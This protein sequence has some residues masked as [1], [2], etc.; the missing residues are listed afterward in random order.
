MALA[1]NSGLVQSHRWLNSVYQR[2]GVDSPNQFTALIGLVII[3]VFCLK[4]VLSYY[5][6][7]YIYTFSY[8]HLADLQKRLLRAYLSVPYT[9]H[10]QNNT[11]LLIQIITEE[12]QRFC[13]N[14]FLPVLLAITNG[15]LILLLVS[16]LAL[17]NLI[18]TVSIAG[19]ILL[20]FVFYLQFRH[21]LF[22]WGKEASEAG[23]EVIRIVNHSIGGIKET[24]VIGCESYFEAQLETQV[25]R[26][27]A[28]FSA[29]MTFNQVPRLVLEAA[30]MLF[31]VGLISL[32][33]IQQGNVNQIIP[34]LTVFGLASIRLLPSVSHFITA[35]GLI[36]NSSYSLQTLYLNLKEV[37]AATLKPEKLQVSPQI[38]QSGSP[39]SS[40]IPFQNSIE[41]KNVTYKYPAV[42]QPALKQISLKV[43][44]G[45]SIALIGKSGAGK[46][47]LVDLI[48][49]LL[50]P[51]S[52]D[53]CVDE[54]SI[55]S[56]L[57]AWQ[58]LIG[59]IP[60][61]IFLIDDTLERNIAFGVPDELIDYERLERAIRSAQLE[62]LIKQLPDGW[63]T[64]VGERGVR[65]SG[66]QRQR[67]GIARAL[68]H[69]REVLVLD[70]ATAALDN[71][72]E[73]LV[74][75]AI[76]TLSGT[77]T[78]IIIA[79]RLT[80]VKN[81]DRIYLMEKGEIVKMVSYA[82]VIAE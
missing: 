9:F 37:E 54:Q 43:L 58:N 18:A 53:I 76:Q 48:L 55:Y 5:N 11:A 31:L 50:I 32:T 81:C 60:Q 52:G 68:Y 29:F 73:R 39:T 23:T 15:I 6:F 75:D 59:Y 51:E 19:L 77:K 65:L 2:S 34:T 79:H 64:H 47:T 12:T 71:E 44:K 67:V 13:N 26:R 61:S 8:K 27:S 74:T 45:Q 62:E 22:L 1:S 69:E 16:L 66:G 4:L 36:K 14:V 30:L 10:L 46:T 57:R 56:N 80:T 38:L 40:T 17:T 3:G 42:E 49:G 7:R 35:F 72:T 63:K 70:E 24:R 21:R 28:A 20:V 78:L 82:E 33:L 41:L 25:K